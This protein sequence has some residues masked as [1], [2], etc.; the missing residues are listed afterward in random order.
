M[1]HIFIPLLLLFVFGMGCRSSPTAKPA[2]TSSPEMNTTGAPASNIV[3]LTATNNMPEY[4]RAFIETV[5][6]RWYDLVDNNIVFSEYKTGHVT[7]K[8]Q[9]YPDGR[10]SSVRVVEN[11]CGEALGLLCQ[12]AVLDLAPYQPWSAEMR[13]LY[14]KQGHDYREINF[15]FNYN[16]SDQPAWQW[17]NPRLKSVK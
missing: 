13:E 10:I 11:T 6:K 3:L 1:N 7:L 2:S 14:K 9:L 15:T 8:F 16:T 12:K 17:R 5:E 4:D